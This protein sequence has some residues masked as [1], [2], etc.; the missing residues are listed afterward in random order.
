MTRTTKC[1]SCRKDRREWADRLCR[2]CAKTH[3]RTLTL[4]ELGEADWRTTGGR[5][6]I[7]AWLTAA[8]HDLSAV[9]HVQ[10]HATTAQVFRVGEPAAVVEL[11]AERAA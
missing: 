5:A 4:H 10:I 2:K 7:T 1:R 3:P 11:T 8:G 9:W 6:R